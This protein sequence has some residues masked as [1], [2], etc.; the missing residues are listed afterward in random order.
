[1][2]NDYAKFKKQNRLLIETIY[3]DFFNN[4]QGS[5][6]I[7]KEAVVL[8]NLEVIINTTLKLSSEM[9]FQSMS[10][11]DLSRESGLSMG[12]L[13]TYFNSKDDLLRIIHHFGMQTVPDLLTKAIDG[14][15]DTH[16]KLSNVVQ[17]HLYLS[18]MMQLWFQFFF[19]ETKN[20]TQE[21]RKIPFE[22]E[23]FTEQ[24][25]IDILEEGRQS[26]LYSIQDTT[27]TAALI[28]ALLQNW[29]L[30][31]WKFAKQKIS[32]EQY[33]TFIIDSIETLVL[34]KKEVKA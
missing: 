21:D 32:I 34:V 19:M 24:I 3:R 8:K 13:Y 31:R 17:T 4:N 12:A 29:Y 25:I 11:R 18:E 27:L 6:K 26:G 16:K 30:K 10:L 14:V 22:S 33:L 7:K 5:L 1:M 2:A 15:S 23:L 28:K 20:L 9:G